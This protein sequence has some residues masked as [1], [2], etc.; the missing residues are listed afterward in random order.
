ME[1]EEGV[2]EEE[3]EEE[4]EVQR[5]RVLEVS[6]MLLDRL[7]SSLFGWLVG[8]VNCSWVY[9]LSWALFWRVLSVVVFKY[10]VE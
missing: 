8:G 2:V 9:F 7:V 5:R 4:E 1:E 10:F 3:E 6:G